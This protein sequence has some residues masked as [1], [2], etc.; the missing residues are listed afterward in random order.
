M[1]RPNPFLRTMFFRV[2]PI[3]LSLARSTM[4]SSTTLFSNNR[5]VQ[6]A[7]RGPARQLSSPRNFGVTKAPARSDRGG[8]HGITIKINGKTRASRPDKEDR[9]GSKPSARPSRFQ[10][11]PARRRRLEAVLS[12]PASGS[13]LLHHQRRA[14]R[15]RQPQSALTG[16]IGAEREGSALDLR[17]SKPNF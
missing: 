5:K 3:V 16:V 12:V 8:S 4:P 13:P 11:G 2:H 6:R 9:N 17:S 10:I 14:R 15:R 1:P 7:L